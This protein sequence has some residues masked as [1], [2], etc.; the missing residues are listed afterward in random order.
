[1]RILQGLALVA[2]LAP[3]PALAHELITHYGAFLGPAL[4]I[5]TEIDHLAAFMVVGLLAGQNESP[6]RTYGVVAFLVAFVLGMV[7]PLGFVGLDGFASVEGLL[8]AA[9]VLVTG[10][11]VAAG[12]QLPAGLIA[13]V[14]TALGLTH[15]IANGFAIAASPRVMD[16]VLGAGI[17]ALV[18]TVVGVLIAA[19]LGG[20]RGRLVVR[21]VGSWVAA[22]SL[23]L[24]G[25]ALRE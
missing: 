1:M 21:V 13:L 20:P 16:S 10:S 5:F 24:I 12:M 4:H 18:I 3:A 15:G 22:L 9:S 25:L 17:A 7:A 6:A 14:S 23:L 2:A 8:S 19:A 11:L